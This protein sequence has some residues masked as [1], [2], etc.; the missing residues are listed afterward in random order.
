MSSPGPIMSR[1]PWPRP[2][3]PPPPPNMV[4]DDLVV[5]CI[6][7]EDDE[8]EKEDFIIP[9]EERVSETKRFLLMN[10]IK[11][12]CSLSHGNSQKSFQ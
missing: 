7:E 1:T 9:C 2:G 11:S 5:D 8:D 4:D 10:L 12:Q 3:M 6:D